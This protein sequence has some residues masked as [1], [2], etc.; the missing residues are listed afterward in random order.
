MGIN[1]LVIENPKEFLF[2]VKIANLR[3]WSYIIEYYGDK[4]VL[5]LNQLVYEKQ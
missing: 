4:Q 1:T 3:K 2:W 5:I